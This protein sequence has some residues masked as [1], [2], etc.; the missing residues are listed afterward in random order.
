MIRGCSRTSCLPRTDDF[1][2]FGAATAGPYLLADAGGLTPREDEI[3][4]S[5]NYI[6]FFAQ[7]DWRMGD[8]LTVNL[9]LRWEYDSE[10]EAKETS[11]RGSA[12]RGR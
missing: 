7:D 5:N 4:L 2:R 1:Q 11:R 10:F 3:H 9:G 8:K 12:C 6:A